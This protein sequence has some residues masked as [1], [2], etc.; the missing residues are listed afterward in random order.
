VLSSEQVTGSKK[1]LAKALGTSTV[2]LDRWLERFGDEVP[3][4]QRGTNGLAYRF[5]LPATVAFFQD[6]RDE[7]ARR[8]A[9][10]DQALAQLALP[11]LDAPQQAENKPISM[12]EQRE[13]LLVGKLKREE[14]ERLGQLVPTAELRDLLGTAFARWNTA[15]HAAIRQ[16]GGDFHLPDPV[17]RELDSRIGLAQR[18]FVRDLRAELLP[19]PD[20]SAA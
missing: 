12:R 15:I 20:A 8:Q 18:E 14:S 11:F 2:T 7:E 19:D 13:A 5:D 1:D 4:L 16:I 6:K 3:C 10:R 9:D 17:T